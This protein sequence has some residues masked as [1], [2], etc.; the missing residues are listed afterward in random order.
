[1]NLKVIGRNPNADW[2]KQWKLDQE[3]VKGEVSCRIRLLSH[4]LDHSRLAF[5]L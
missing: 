5:F 4:S 2:L 1:M 3:K